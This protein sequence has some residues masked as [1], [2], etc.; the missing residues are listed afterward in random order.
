MVGT[1][2]PC[3]L[4]ACSTGARMAHR[5]SGGADHA[6]Q[7]PLHTG[8]G[9]RHPATHAPS[10][11]AAFDPHSLHLVFCRRCC[12]TGAHGRPRGMWP[13]AASA[14]RAWRCG[15]GCATACGVSW[16][17]TLR[18][19]ALIMRSER[20][21]VSIS[22]AAR[23]RPSARER[24]PMA[25]V[26]QK[27]PRCWLLGSKPGPGSRQH[28][29]ISAQALRSFFSRAFPTWGPPV[30][31]HGAPVAR[32]RR[33]S[34]LTRTVRRWCTIL[35]LSDALAELAGGNSV[36]ILRRRGRR[37]LQWWREWLSQRQEKRRQVLG[38]L[39][40]VDA[41]LQAR[42]FAAWQ[43][44]AVRRRELGEVHGLVAAMLQ[45]AAARRGLHG[46]H[47]HTV[48]AH[49]FERVVRSALGRLM[50]RTLR[51]A[52]E[53]WRQHALALSQER[54]IAQ[55][56]SRSVLEGSW[57]GSLERWRAQA[58]A[59]RRLR[60]VLERMRHGALRR[61]L[62]FWA[63]R[64]VQRAECRSMEGLV[65]GRM[66]LFRCGRGRRV[67]VQHHMRKD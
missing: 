11:V 16:S 4:M 61:C 36:R 20:W 43:G 65:L 23:R 6:V 42:C 62:R 58:A 1:S 49:H 10:P 66:R 8:D 24:A 22:G 53:T 60:T 18:R 7:G 64:V 33:R 25:R 55:D 63:A 27:R 37:Y 59:R 19:G 45:R 50:A 21:P 5:S 15:V 67:R 9:L 47:A 35:K 29:L 51:G 52:M 41:G 48:R 40:H 56:L 3:D 26:W 13:V 32:C 38:Y 2:V 17:S 44:R 31:H 46:W 54:G 39:G 57:R 28:R 30:A 12:S 14:T 34:A